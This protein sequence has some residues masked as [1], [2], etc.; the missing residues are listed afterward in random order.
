MFLIQTHD[1][2][3]IYKQRK[4]HKLREDWS[5]FCEWIETL[6]YAKELIIGGNETEIRKYQDVQY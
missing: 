3:T 4:N 5:A 2:K 6:P 1:L